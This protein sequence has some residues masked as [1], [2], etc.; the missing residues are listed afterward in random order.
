MRGDSPNVQPPTRTDRPD[1]ARRRLSHLSGVRREAT[2]VRADDGT[3]LAA[4]WFRPRDPVRGHLLVAPAMATP[5]RFYLDFA[6]WLAHRGF[7]VLTFDYRST[8]APAAELRKERADLLTW[9][10][11]AAAALEHVAADQS[12]GVGPSDITWIGH[13]FG[14]QVLP[15]VRHDLITRAVLVATGNGYFHHNPPWL[16]RRAP[17][18]WR[19]LVPATTS[20]VGY[21]PGRRLGIL[22]DLPAGVARQWGRWCLHPGYWA[23]DVPDIAARHA[24]I[25]HPVAFVSVS[26]DALVTAAGPAAMAAQLTGARVSTIEV[27]PTTLGVPAV[28]H[29]GLFRRDLM[30]AWDGVFTPLLPGEPALSGAR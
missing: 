27:E 11:D 24:L 1:V 5:A 7:T 13:S 18:L 3:L 28:G 22:G 25:T 16:R 17:L 6:S 12:A 26:D 10:A 9:A 29:H 30:S 23:A 8:D 21:F 20:M 15:F 19:V 4:T 2:T 14:G